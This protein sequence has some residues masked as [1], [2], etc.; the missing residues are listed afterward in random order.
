MVTVYMWLPIRC[1]WEISEIDAYSIER[2]AYSAT[3]C[4]NAVLMRILDLRR[5][6]T[7]VSMAHYYSVD[8]Q[9]SID[10]IDFSQH[11]I[12]QTCRTVA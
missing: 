1:T 5:Y 11:P 7:V 12:V 8:V 2:D 9:P 10:I 6:E 3:T 4:K